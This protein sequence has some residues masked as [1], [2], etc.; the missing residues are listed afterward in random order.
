MSV[1]SSLIDYYA[2]RAHEYERIYSKPERQADLTLLR[3][4]LQAK[5]LHQDVLEVACGTGYWTEAIA[6]T[7]NSV[8]AV[9]INR[10]VLAI[11]RSKRFIR[12]N[13][14]FEKQDAYALSRWSTR[15]TLGLA[16]FW[17][18]H[19]PKSKLKSF[20]QQFHRCLQPDALV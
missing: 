14:S 4:W 15:F 11:A 8:I 13:V 17:W 5:C 3:Q 1:D 16:A 7:A 6:V 20:L 18:S 2:R 19:I 10:A 9:D 12:H